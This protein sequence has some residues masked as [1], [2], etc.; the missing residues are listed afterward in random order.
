MRLLAISSWFPWPADNGSKLRAYHL[1]EVLAARHEITLLSFAEPG[2]GQDPG[3]LLRL[4]ERVTTVQGNPFK[5]RKPLEWR[6]YW[7]GTPRSF[8]QT[9]SSEMQAH[10]DEEVLRHDAAIAFQIGAALYLDHH[11]RLARVVDEIE[12]GVIHDAYASMPFGVGRVRRGLT[13]WKYSQFIRSLVSG[14]HHATVVSE[15]ERHHLAAAGCDVGPVSVLPNG[16]DRTDL[17]RSNSPRPARLIYPGSVTYSANLDAVRFFIEHIFPRIRAARPDATL[18]VTGA[19]G[20]VDVGR[21]QVP[22][23]TFTGRVDDVK[24]LVSRSMACVVP[25]RIGGG[26]RLKILESLA[27]GTPVVSTPKGAEGL[28]VT[29]EHDVLLAD[30]P[31]DFAAQVVRLLDDF[32][33]RARLSAN[34]R[35]TVERQYTW[36]RIGAQLNGIIEDA[37]RRQVRTTNTVMASGTDRRA[38]A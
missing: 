4:C 32:A 26:T 8:A 9:Y 22:G 37:A 25:L 10:V 19:I 11:A 31:E 18:Q 20:D 16:V 33:L 35:R 6:G 30:S 3:P 28:S 17:C 15:K 12:V 21:F 36:D 38:R 7:S 14:F 23:V 2:E 1:L 13:W 24:E 5:P 29:P 34:G 27:L